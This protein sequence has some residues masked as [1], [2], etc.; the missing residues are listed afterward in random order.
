MNA[1]RWTAAAMTAALAACSGGGASRQSLVPTVQ[2]QSPASGGRAT[3]TFAIAIPL[4]GRTTGATQRKT[5]YFSA[6]TASFTVQIVS[7]NGQ[8][9]SGPQPHAINTGPGLPNCTSNDTTLTCTGS[10]DVPVGTDVL[11]VTATSGTNNSGAPLS[12][13][14]VIAQIS[15]TAANAISVTLDGVV[16][17]VKVSFPASQPAPG[18]PQTIPV[19][20]S[21]ADCSGATIIGP[22]NYT[23]PIALT[24]TD[25]SGSTTLSS[26][27][28]TSPSQSV[29]LAWD[30]SNKLQYAGITGTVPANSVPCG[31]PFGFQ[32][33]NGQ[34]Q[35]GYFLPHPEPPYLWAAQSSANASAGAYGWLVGYPLSWL[36]NPG[37]SAQVRPGPVIMTPGI[38][39]RFAGVDHAGDVYSS[40]VDG[41]GNPGIYKFAA[42]ATFN[43][44][45]VANIAN[46]SIQAAGAKTNAAITDLAVDPAGNVYIVRGGF[47][48]ANGQN[49]N[50]DL[51]EFAGAGST[52]AA[53]YHD[54]G[55]NGLNAPAGMG[56]DGSGNVFVANG[57]SQNPAA[58][59]LIEKF[60]NGAPQSAALPQDAQG[61]YQNATGFGFD[62]TGR[63]YVGLQQSGHNP[64]VATYAIAAFPSAANGGFSFLPQYLGNSFYSA[65]A[66]GAD[67]LGYTYASS[68][69]G[70]INVF[71]PGASGSATPIASFQCCIDP[72]TPDGTIAVPAG[73]SPPG[74]GVSSIAVQP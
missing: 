18:S 8:T 19:T 48:D 36:R 55:N 66:I 47:V 39:L 74:N 44:T 64:S 59:G 29:T 69:Y 58:P 11:A 33:P 50:A 41:Q 17:G 73:L 31:N 27:T 38:G 1:I 52:A 42:G 3:A 46:A 25:A 30:G 35:T 53:I 45:P 60:G 26:T 43:A 23:T 72:T 28:V 70:I 13:G 6:N 4:A 21:A 61:N 34:F 40:Y 49:A 71:A 5:D 2:Q 10:I 12:M 24:N 7:N 51:L 68:L 57:S 54:T 67:S 16:A 65:N 9:Y 37:S 56:A 20:V 22:G 63:V 14:Q 15:P 62:G 32:H